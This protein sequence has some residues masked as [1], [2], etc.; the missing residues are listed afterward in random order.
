MKIFDKYYIMLLN[1]C[2]KS[3][4]PEEINFVNIIY[5]N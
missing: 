2:F 1:N 4:K 5:I 3:I